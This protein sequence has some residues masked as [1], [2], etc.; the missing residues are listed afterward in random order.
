MSIGEVSLHFNI[1]WLDQILAGFRPIYINI[2]TFKSDRLSNVLCLTSAVKS[3]RG[4]INV[5]LQL[6]RICKVP[7]LY[8]QFD[9]SIEFCCFNWVNL[10]LVLHFSHQGFNIRYHQVRFIVIATT[11]TTDVF[12]RVNCTKF[13]RIMKIVVKHEIEAMQNLIPK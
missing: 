6:E 3:S 2:S 9:D 1:C 10:I 8:F 5:L 7:I 12:D 13:R 11:P 4:H